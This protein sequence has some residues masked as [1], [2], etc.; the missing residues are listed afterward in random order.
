MSATFSTIL[1]VILISIG[2]VGF[3]FLGMSLTQIFKGHD[4]DSE[5]ATNKD[6]QRLGIKC[7]VQESREDTGTDCADIGCHGNCSSCDI[8]HA[9][10]KK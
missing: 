4:I 9:A 1:I 10:A 7:A 5:I 8:D 6:M 2:M 3:F